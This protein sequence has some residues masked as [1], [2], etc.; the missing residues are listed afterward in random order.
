MHYYIVS[1]F[2]LLAK[3]ICLENQEKIE[4]LNSN[5]VAMNFVNALMEQ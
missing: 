5:K 3:R 4:T 2:H 1:I